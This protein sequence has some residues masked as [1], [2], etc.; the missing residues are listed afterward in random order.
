MMVM[1]LQL[2]INIAQAS[3]C[4]ISPTTLDCVQV[5]HV[6]DGDTLIVNLPGVHPIIGKKI[7]VRIYGID[8]PEM[9]GKNP[10][11]REAA[12]DAKTFVEKEISSKKITLVNIK[13]DKYFRIL[14]KVEV[15][16]ESLADKLI[17]AKLAYPYFG[18][19]KKNTNWCQPGPMPSPN[20]K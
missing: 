1:L 10:C 19:I 3:S 14:A 17:A 5:D 16:G 8:T 11:E 12:K 2:F 13:R 20:S 18:K 7:P 6:Y 15:N 9:N 4:N